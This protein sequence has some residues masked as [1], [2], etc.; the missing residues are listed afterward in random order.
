MGTLTRS[1]QRLSGLQQLTWETVSDSSVRKRRAGRCLQVQI[2]LGKRKWCYW[3]VFIGRKTQS[4][5]VKIGNAGAPF[6]RWVK[7]WFWKFARIQPVLNQPGSCLRAPHNRKLF[8]A[9]I[10]SVMILIYDFIYLIIQSFVSW[11]FERDIQLGI[12]TAV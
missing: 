8:S 2:I 11:I 12:M 6:F 10:S 9:A 3:V 4:T 7:R 1:C 5:N